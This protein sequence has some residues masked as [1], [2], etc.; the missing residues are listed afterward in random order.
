MARCQCGTSNA[1]DA[2]FCSACGDAL[3]DHAGLL[4]V[5]TTVTDTAT[6]GGIDRRLLSIAGLLLAAVIGWATW[7]GSD[8][9]EGSLDGELAE[10]ATTT[11]PEQ[12]TTTTAPRTTTT[13]GPTTTRNTEPEMSAIGD[14]RPL[15]GETTGLRMIL[16]NVSERPTVLD[17][18]TGELIE[19]AGMQGALEPTL[20]SGDR[21]VGRD[22]DKL[23][24]VPVGD[25]AAAPVPLAPEGADWIDVVSSAP[26]A[27][28][29][30]WIYTY[31]ETQEVFLVDVATGAVIAG[32]PSPATDLAL[33]NWLPGSES[34]AESILSHQSGG[35]YEA[36]S[37][38]F[39]LVADGRLVTGDDDRALT[40]MCDEF[41]RCDMQWFD[42]S[43]W[44]PIDLAVPAQRA[45]SIN[46]L[47]GSDWLYLQQWNP[48]NQSQALF[49]VVNGRS[50]E[51]D[52]TIIDPYRNQGPAISPDGRWLAYK[53]G[54]SLAII[55]LA[56]GNERTFDSING[57]GAAMV[58]TTAKAGYATVETS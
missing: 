41:L 40:E 33:S 11:N 48:D 12:T 24:A 20:V 9:P 1:D 30:L 49:N 35:V 36:R 4:G 15:L 52:S 29:L 22:N 45:D 13:R 8:T 56:T 43:T 7:S 21:L 26:R 38:G 2:R 28:G 18:D 57:L 6:T 23:V 3:G 53:S 50:I 5:S 27:D 37:D 16:G 44:K 14:G 46:F 17:L 39:R 34:G 32:M 42:R 54:V 51:L 25:L 19:A 31:D 10:Q 47:G 58:F 55:D